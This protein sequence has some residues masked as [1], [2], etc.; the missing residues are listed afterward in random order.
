M[1]SQANSAER[2]LFDETAFMVAMG[3]DSSDAKALLD[4][5]LAE[6]H[7]ALEKLRRD[8]EAKDFEG[9]QKAAD[10]MRELALAI[11]SETI[12]L[13]AIQTFRMALIRN[14]DDAEMSCWDLADCI[15]LLELQLR[16]KGWIR[17][18]P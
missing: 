15:K 1:D 4:A 17:K 5:A 3:D 9:A 11:S 14:A 10:A 18:T 12:A 7:L 16:L 2:E 8:I 13:A 6:M